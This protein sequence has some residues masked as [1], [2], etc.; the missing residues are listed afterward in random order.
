MP[1]TPTREVTAVQ[2]SWASHRPN[3]SLHS[4]V[5]SSTCRAARTLS[6]LKKPVKPP[7]T[8]RFS[9]PVLMLLMRPAALSAALCALSAA[10]WAF[11]V[12]E[13][14]ERMMRVR[15]SPLSSSRGLLNLTILIYYIT[16]VVLLARRL[17][18]L[19]KRDV[20]SVVFVIGD[21]AGDDE[22]LVLKDGKVIRV[23]VERGVVRTHR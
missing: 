6:L 1:V 9:F 13:K 21:H 2:P 22:L 12:A 15:L 5:P 11:S 20:S 4:S 7:F 16:R 19:N 10:F 3:G 14:R 8:T 23:A 18:L 17:E